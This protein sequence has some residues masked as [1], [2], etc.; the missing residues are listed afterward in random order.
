MDAVNGGDTDNEKMALLAYETYVMVEEMLFDI[1]DRKWMSP[2]SKLILLGGIMINMD[3]DAPDLFLPLNFE[4]ISGDGEHTYLMEKVFGAD[5]A[6]HAVKATPMRK[7]EKGDNKNDLV[8]KCIPCKPTEDC[9]LM[10]AAQKA[11][12]AVNFP[13]A[14]NGRE[15]EQMVY[16][17]LAEHGVNPTNTVLTQSS[18]PDE[19]NHDEFSQDL[20]QIMGNRWGEVFHLGGLAGIPFTGLTGWG[21]FSH[22]VPKDGNIIVLLAP[23]VGLTEE[24]GVGKVHRH[25]QDHSTSACGAAVGAYNLLK[26]DPTANTRTNE[27]DFQ[28]DYI[29]KALAPHMEEILAASGVNARQTL[30]ANK[31]HDIA[32]QFLDEIVD[33]KWMGPNSKLVILSGLMINV[34]GASADVFEP[35]SFTI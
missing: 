28:Q 24:G 23:H 11:S 31:M 27:N 19:L 29:V 18:C 26:K 8:N 9:G 12:L 34:D 33:L 32:S 14:M 16:Q 20:S 2:D 25:G 21:A 17:K 4:S 22:H 7:C 15:L 5:Q 35:L 10:T 13:K 3:G 30:L 1:V 6:D